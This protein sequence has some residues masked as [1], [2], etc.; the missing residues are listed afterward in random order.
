MVSQFMAGP[1]E[2]YCMS[3]LRIVVVALSKSRIETCLYFM[4]EKLGPKSKSL[5]SERSIWNNFPRHYFCEFQCLH[6]I[7]III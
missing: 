5:K 7:Y 1:Y 4:K 2:S 6:L 3:I